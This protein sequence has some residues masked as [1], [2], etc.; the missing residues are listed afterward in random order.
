M[1]VISWLFILAGLVS[2]Y[3]HGGLNYGIDFLGGTSVQVR[4]TQPQSIGDVRAALDRPELRSAVVQEAGTGGR[5]FQIRV[6]GRSEEAG[7]A[8]ADVVKAGLQERFGEGTYDVLRVETVGPTV[9]S[10]E[11]RVGT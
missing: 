3:M 8:D 7:S 9:R 10:E 6:Q 11:R 4:F 1:I 2:I 5:E